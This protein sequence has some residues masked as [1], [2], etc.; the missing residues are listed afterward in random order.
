M[1]IFK[2]EEV[3]FLETLVK[4]YKESR[5]NLKT[6]QDELMKLTKELEKATESLNEIRDREKKFVDTIAEREGLEAS[7]VIKK[8]VEYLDTTKK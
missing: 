6:K 3:Q 1:E 5:Q 4:D 7:E 2:N 8:V